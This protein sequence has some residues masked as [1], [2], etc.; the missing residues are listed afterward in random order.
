HADR[1]VADKSGSGSQLAGCGQQSVGCRT[2]TFLVHDRSALGLAGARRA[3]HVARLA[4]DIG[5]A[6]CSGAVGVGATLSG[7]GGVGS[8]ARTHWRG[9]PV[10]RVEQAATQGNYALQMTFGTQRY[11]GVSLNWFLG[12]WRGYKALSFDVFNPHDDNLPLMIR[13]HDL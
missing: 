2:G 3:D 9:G 10:E 4:A 5:C 8:G 7:A 6:Y 12:D 11:S 13:I 1:M